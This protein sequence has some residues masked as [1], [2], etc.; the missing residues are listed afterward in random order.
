VG[1]DWFDIIPLSGARVAL[2]VGDVVGHGIQASATGERDGAGEAGATC[3]YAVYDPI[4]RVLSAASAGHPPPVVVLPDGSSQVLDLRAGPV[5]GIGGLPFEVGEIEL[6]EHSLIAL[7]SDGLVEA[8]DHDPD[9]GI[10]RLRRLLEEPGPTLEARCDRVLSAMLPPHPAD[11]AALVLASSRAL[12]A[13]QFRAWDLPSDPEIVAEAR[14]LVDEQLQAWG[15]TEAGFVTELVVSELVTNAIRYG[16]EP[17]ELRLIHDG[18]LICEVSDGNS[19]SP[20]L[21]RARTSD[22]GGRGLLLVAQLTTNWG[23]RH[24]ATG[25]TIWAEQSLAPAL[26]PVV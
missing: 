11:D 20:H 15:L 10:E 25:K 2:V 18:S 14:R 9:R 26:E 16:D 3:L 1:G 12:G 6:P 4:S 22:E 21:R 24:T 19:A 5:L 23:M 17:I 13:G 8:V 7:Y